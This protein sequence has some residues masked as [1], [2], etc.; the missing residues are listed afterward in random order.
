MQLSVDQ[1]FHACVEYGE[2]RNAND[3]AENTEQSAEYGNGKNHPESGKPCGIA[4]NLG[5][6]NVAVKLL[7]EN[8][9]DTKVERLLGDTISL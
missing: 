4:K 8:D 3:H 2:N 1:R 9:Q 5:A 6:Q 7:D